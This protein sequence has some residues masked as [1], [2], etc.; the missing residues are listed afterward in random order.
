ML[1]LAL[2]S[3]KRNIISEVLNN[4]RKY[5]FVHSNLRTIHRKI[6]SMNFQYPSHL[7]PL[8]FPQ[9]ILLLKLLSN[10]IADREK[11]AT[12]LLVPAC[13]LHKL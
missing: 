3:L 7:Y 8:K 10:V 4:M 6:L 11:R 12:C 2:I 9:K 13:V 5:N 1:I